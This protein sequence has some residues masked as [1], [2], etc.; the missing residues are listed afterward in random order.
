MARLQV[1]GGAFH[2]VRVNLGLFIAE[3]SVQNWN[4]FL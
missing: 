1:N 3:V 2:Y 4:F